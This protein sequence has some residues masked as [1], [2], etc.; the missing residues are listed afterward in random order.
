MLNFAKREYQTR[1]KKTK[2]SMEKQGINVLLITDPAN[3]SYLTGFNAWSFYVHQLLIIIDQEKEPI[4]AG[5][6]IDA[7]AAKITTWLSEDNILP[8]SDD[9]V[10]STEKHPMDFVAGILKE[11]GQSNKTIAAEFDAYYFTARNYIQ[12]TQQLP[13]ATFVD[14]TTLVN[15]IRIIK[16][17]QE[18]E[19]IKRAATIVTETM[20]KGIER[21]KAGVRE[22]DVVADIFHKQISG[23]E[24]FGG[25]YTSIVPLL[26]SGEKTSACHLT[27]TDEV[28]KE[29]DPVVLELAGCHKRYHSPLARTLVIGKPTSEMEELADVTIEGIE[30]ALDVIKPGVTCEEV[31]LAWKRSIEKR[32]FE[33]ESRLGYSTGLNYPPDWG[34]H[35]ASLRSGDQTVLQPNMVFHMIPGIWMDTYGI[36]ISETFRVTEN[37]VEVLANVDRKLFIN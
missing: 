37:G 26:P 9:H 7:S 32:G 8:Y 20:Y 3:I 10:Q 17:E 2:Q 36:E 15:W 27:W 1:L 5:R 35:T 30:A 23:T 13:N 25:D 24:E 21:I 4:W 29:G 22:C 12:L 18:I 33:K 14:G 28:Y 6:G 31:E 34:E 19:Y 16:S 11:K